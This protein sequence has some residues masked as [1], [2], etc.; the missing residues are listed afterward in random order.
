[1]TPKRK[2]IKFTAPRAIGGLCWL[3]DRRLHAGGRSYKTAV[4]DGVERPVHARCLDK[5]ERDA[6]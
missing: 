4:V 5:M 1:M 6:R 3:C 2:P